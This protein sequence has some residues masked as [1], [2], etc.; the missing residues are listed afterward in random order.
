MSP[1]KALSR[2]QSTREAES[3][4]LDYDEDFEEHVLPHI[5]AR[6]GYS[7]YWVRAKYA[8]VPD[9]RNLLKRQR[10]GWKPRPPETVPEIF[11]QLVVNEESLGGVISTHDLILMERPIAIQERR[12]KRHRERVDQ[13]ERAVKQ[14]IFREHAKLGGEE[15]GITAPQVIDKK[16][17]ERGVMLKD[18]DT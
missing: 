13:L 3:Q 2:D 17:V 18:S 4:A 9:V 7:Q 1:E 8:G 12:K 5:P 11:R 16:R 10:Q 15:V 6:P 14:N